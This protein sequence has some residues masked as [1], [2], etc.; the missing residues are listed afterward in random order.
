MNKLEEELEKRLNDATW[1]R[2]IAG[3]VIEQYQSR[4]FIKPYFKLAWSAAAIII[5]FATL[6]F[7]YYTN[8]NSSNRIYQDN[9]LRDQPAEEFEQLD[10]NISFTE[11]IAYLLN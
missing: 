5:L 7:N 3:A 1:S 8:S 9:V 11:E 10:S 2:K 6:F 4:N